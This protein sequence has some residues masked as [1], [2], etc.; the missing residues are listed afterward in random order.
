[1]PLLPPKAMDSTVVL[2]GGCFWCTEA[3]FNN[4]RGVRGVVS[5]Y[6]GGQGRAPS[7]EDVCTGRTG[8]AECV[9]VI[10]D[11]ATV[12]L[13][14]LLRVF[15]TVHDP[16]TLNRQGA[17]A[18]TQYRSAIF[19]ADEQ[20][21]STAKEVI[22]ELASKGLWDNAPIV[23]SLE[24]LQMFHPAEPYHQRYFEQHQTQGYC[25]VVIEPKLAKLRQQLQPLLNA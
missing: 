20:Q 19:Y 1:M 4:V 8:F 23:T 13:E 15:F 21:L 16:T 12:S 10:Y 18:G 11:P 17:D 14:N 24:P 25:Q 9:Q 6:S 2:A 22:A 5:G 7:Y 3:A